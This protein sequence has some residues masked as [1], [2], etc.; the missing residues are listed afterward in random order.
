[1]KAQHVRTWL[2]S[3]IIPVRIHIILNEATFSRSP[4]VILKC[5]IIRGPSKCVRGDLHPLLDKLWF[6]SAYWAKPFCIPSMFV[7][8]EWECIV[9]C[10][11]KP[12]GRRQ[13]CF[14]GKYYT[15]MEGK[16]RFVSTQTLLATRC[17]FSQKKSRMMSY[18]SALVLQKVGKFPVNFGN[19]PVFFFLHIFLGFLEFTGNVPP[20]C[21]PNLHQSY[22][23][24]F[25][26]PITQD[27]VLTLRHFKDFQRFLGQANN[28]G[29]RTALSVSSS[30]VS[31]FSLSSK[32]HIFFQ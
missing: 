27:N 19:F 13:R 11:F 23:S 18:R 10:T 12:V 6:Y 16:G 2:E 22:W 9:R 30:S 24:P 7:S 1:M 29:K 15:N 5:Q 17:S 32:S 25:P 21:N 4:P 28:W 26:F 31:Y 3:S 20:L 8:R 14:A